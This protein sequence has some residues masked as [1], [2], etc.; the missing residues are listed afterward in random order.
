MNHF[1]RYMID[2]GG[3]TIDASLDNYGY[4]GIRFIHKIL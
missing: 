2:K 1:K 3:L 4:G